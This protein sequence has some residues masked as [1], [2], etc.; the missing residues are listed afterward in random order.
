MLLKKAH[1]LRLLCSCLCSAA[2]AAASSPGSQIQRGRPA[3]A[4]LLHISTGIEQRAHS[5]RT[6]VPHGTM[7]RGHATLVSG[8]RV[9]AG[10]DEVGYQGCLSRWIPPARAWHTIDCIVKRLGASP[11]L[12]ANVGAKG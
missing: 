5:C 9:G 3:F 11:I 6:S 8:I 7:Q 10:R 4:E 12:G 2:A 1:D